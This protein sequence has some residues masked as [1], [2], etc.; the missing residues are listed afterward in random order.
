MSRTYPVIDLSESSS[1][2]IEARSTVDPHELAA[3]LKDIG[4][5]IAP[6]LGEDQGKDAFGVKSV[7]ISLSVGAE[8]GV[9]FIA[10]G[11]A[12]ASIKL[13]LERPA[14]VA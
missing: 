10:K 14:A 7:E 12:E 4:D 13:V 1:L 6:I 2:A 5:A 8:G 11:S 9:W 3:Q